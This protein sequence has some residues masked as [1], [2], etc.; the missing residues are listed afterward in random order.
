MSTSS[1]ISSG[2]AVKRE[3]LISMNFNVKKGVQLVI[4]SGLRCALN[5]IK[6]SHS[7][8]LL[9]RPCSLR[10]R[11]SHAGMTGTRH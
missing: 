2:A 11:T 6:V 4:T 3:P 8:I 1:D 7:S 9:A 5:R 10:R